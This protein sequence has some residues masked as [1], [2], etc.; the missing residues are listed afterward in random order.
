MSNPAKKFSKEQIQEA[1]A[2]LDLWGKFSPPDIETVELTL[3]GEI[4]KEQF[5]EAW[6]GISAGDAGASRDGTTHSHVIVDDLQNM[7]PVQLSDLKGT[8]PGITGGLSSEEFV[9]RQRQGECV[10]KPELY[11]PHGLHT[12]GCGKWHE[13]GCEIIEEAPKNPFSF[14]PYCGGELKVLKPTTDGEP[15]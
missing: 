1:I 9:R 12:T 6:K 2:V 11:D 7:P 8:A 14:C 15:T 5:D 13:T 4:T 10:W 3:G